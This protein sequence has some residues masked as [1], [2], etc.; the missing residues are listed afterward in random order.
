MK[1][2]DKTFKGNLFSSNVPVDYKRDT[3]GLMVGP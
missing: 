1:E 3:N 2:F